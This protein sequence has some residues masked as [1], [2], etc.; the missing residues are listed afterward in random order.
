MEIHLPD[1][2]HHFIQKWVLL[3]KK[4]IYLH[5]NSR[6]WYVLFEISVI[7]VLEK[8]HNLPCFNFQTMLKKKS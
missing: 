1:F 4:L 5:N 2:I 7:Y 3:I 8:K 6:I